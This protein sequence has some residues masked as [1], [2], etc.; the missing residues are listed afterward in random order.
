MKG[1]C[2]TVRE[3]SINLARTE[4]LKCQNGRVTLLLL[5]VCKPRSTMPLANSGQKNFEHFWGEN[6]QKIPKHMLGFS[7]MWG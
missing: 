4:A 2:L 5:E 3:M 1:K 6:Y 7:S